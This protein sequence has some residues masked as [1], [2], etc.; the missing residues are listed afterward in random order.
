LY[1]GIEAGFRDLS[2]RIT[3]AGLFIGAPECQATAE[4]FHMPELTRV[5]DL[6]TARAAIET[7]VAEGEGVRGDWRDAHFG[8]FVA[9]LERYRALRRDDPNFTPARSVVANPYVHRVEDAWSGAQTNLLEDPE[10]RAFADLFDA[11]YQLMTEMLERYFAHGEESP[12]EL[13]T[14]ADVAI[15]LMSGVVAPLGE[16][17]TRLP[18]GPHLPGRT[19]GPCFAIGSRTSF[20]IH[21]RAAWRAQ[22]E[23]ILSLSDDCRSMAVGVE[24]S[25]VLAST[26]EML[27]GFAR[28]LAPDGE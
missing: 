21:K 18:A 19:A 17:L 10:T 20:T 12:S 24:A 6:R 9:M 2:G 13:A 8:R 7:I 27:Q 22:R 15:G 14:L 5:A 16:L 11:C 28:R 3:E 26:G 23:R 1:R 25:S 4:Q